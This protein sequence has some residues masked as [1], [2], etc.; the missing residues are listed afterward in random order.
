MRRKP[1]GAQRIRNAG[2]IHASEY[3][4]ALSVVA[5]IVGLLTLAIPI[6]AKLQQRAGREQERLVLNQVAGD[7]YRDSS[8]KEYRVSELESRRDPE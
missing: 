5:I 3:Y 8:G 7:L 6:L 1:A 2:E 4:R